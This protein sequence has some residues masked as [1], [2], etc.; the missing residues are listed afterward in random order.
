[1][2]MTWHVVMLVVVVVRILARAS[3]GGT[4]RCLMTYVECP[5]LELAGT[6]AIPPTARGEMVVVV[7]VV[8]LAGWM[9]PAAG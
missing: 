6:A 7:V 5:K 2:M 4:E 3:R 1:M 9:P 8:V